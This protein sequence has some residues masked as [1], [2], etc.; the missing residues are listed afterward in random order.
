MAYRTNK[1]IRRI[2]DDNAKV[3]MSR[4]NW[5]AADFQRNFPTLY[6]AIKI[7]MEDFARQTWD[8]ARKLKDQ[9]LAIPKEN[10][11]FKNFNDY[12]DSIN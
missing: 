4:D 7:S 2:F 6:K 8:N 11:E 12:L 1:T 5:F 3:I 10:L 9:N